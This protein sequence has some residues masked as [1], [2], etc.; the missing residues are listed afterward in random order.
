MIAFYNNLSPTTR[1]LLQSF[2]SV[3]GSVLAGV[4]TA[5]YQSYTQAGHLDFQGLL[6]VSLVT[7]ALLFGKTMH[8]W[9]PNHAQ[10]LIQ[11][12]KDSEA[13][14][15]D[16][17]QRQQNISSAAVAAQGKQVASTTAP[18]TPAPFIIQT[19]SPIT[20]EHVQAISQQIA[21]NLA[22]MAA[23]SQ[24]P[25]TSTQTPVV[26][27]AP[28]QAQQDAYVDPMRNSAVLPAYTPPA[29][30]MTIADQVTQNV[31]TPQLQFAIP[32]RPAT[33]P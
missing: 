14:L 30:S 31:P 10:Q 19:T 32:A 17:L 18:V 28:A 15:R 33:M 1:L 7:F 6:N 11:V 5:G 8:D 16:A 27:Q 13:Q 9:V 12:Y 4:A 2:F 23:S 22:N 29:V 25:A 3:L 21:V 20:P 26:P 24:Q